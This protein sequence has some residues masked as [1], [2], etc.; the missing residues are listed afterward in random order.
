MASPNFP[1][2][3]I[4]MT[5]ESVEILY[6]LGRQDC[7]AGVSTYVERPPEAK[8]NHPKISAFT[9][10]NLAK[11]KNINPDLIVGFS[12]IQ[13]DI[14]RDL[15]GEGFNVFISNQRSL[16][17]ILDYTLLMGRIVGEEKA[18]EELYQKLRQKIEEAKTQGDQILNRPKVY[19]EEWD[20][21]I[22]SGIQWVSE[23]IELCGGNDICK[24]YAHG[25]MA[26][27]RMPSAEFIIQ[28]N[29]E[30][31][32]GCWCGK[33]MDP[34]NFRKRPHWDLMDAIKK[35]RII[36]LDP[37]IFLQPGPACILDG[38]DILLDIFKNFDSE[39]GQTK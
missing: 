23:L 9:H 37:A 3:I 29:P 13:K 26:K 28:Q 5:E 22:I 36:E 34:E 30:I 20:Y 24:E 35:D 33:K 8:K 32:F 12:D 2:K 31:I 39:V 10:A 1:K 38:I 19:F 4:C 21:P 6:L 16:K 7:I 14:A 11:I 27:D 17:E 18:A 25:K 15:I